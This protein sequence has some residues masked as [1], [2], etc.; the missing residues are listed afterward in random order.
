MPERLSRHE[1]GVVGAVTDYDLVTFRHRYSGGGTEQRVASAAVVDGRIRLFV[2]R[3]EADGQLTELIDS[4]S[5]GRTATTAGIARCGSVDLAEDGSPAPLFAVA[6][7]DEETWV[8]FFAID[9]VGVVGPCQGGTGVNLHATA[10]RG[11][12]P[13]S[14]LIEPTVHFVMVDAADRLCLA[15]FRWAA[16]DGRVKAPFFTDQAADAHGTV[17]SSAATRLSATG[18][19]TISQAAAEP[20]ARVVV[21][22]E[23]TNPWGTVPATKPAVF[24][25]MHDSGT[26]MVQAGEVAVAAPDGDSGEFLTAYQTTDGATR[27]E[28]R[29]WRSTAS[30]L[31]ALAVSREQGEPVKSLDAAVLRPLTG[32]GYRT[33]IATQES[34]DRLKVTPWNVS[35]TGRIS[36]AGGTAWSGEAT[37]VR[38]DRLDDPLR[39]V[40]AVQTA[41]GDLKVVVWGDDA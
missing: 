35:P 40:T 11:V 5:G 41:N 34:N 15:G 25:R 32:G 19:V 27:L 14:G 2:W 26:L 13:V 21:W 17:S 12:R 18:L 8:D 39:F 1:Q 20:R 16:S 22:A 24:R 38:V 3:V 6:A 33:V 30:G 31:T 29:T 23:G 9:E 10:I 28:L 4:G 37:R 36:R 7:G